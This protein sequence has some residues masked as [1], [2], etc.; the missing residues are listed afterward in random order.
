MANV[1]GGYILI[2]DAQMP[3]PNQIATAFF[4]AFGN[5]ETSL[6]ES[7]E[8]MR[9]TSLSLAALTER[10]ERGTA[11]DLRF[12]HEDVEITVGF[13][14]PLAQFHALWFGIPEHIWFEQNQNSALMDFFAPRWMSVCEQMHATYGFFSGYESLSDDEHVTNVILPAIEQHEV[15]LLANYWLAYLGPSL[16]SFWTE[17]DNMQ[18]RSDSTTRQ[19]PSGALFFRSQASPL[20]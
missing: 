15:A 7:A 3:A 17:Q 5:P 16:A 14:A 19:M 6:S 9:R 13:G 1:T 18:V 8:G 10:V 12:R 4:Q 2:F 11:L 20:G